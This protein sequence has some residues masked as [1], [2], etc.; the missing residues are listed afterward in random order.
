MGTL[1]GIA[2]SARRSDVKTTML[3][4]WAARKTAPEDATFYVA[5]GPSKARGRSAAARQQVMGCI[6]TLAA[7]SRQ[8]ALVGGE[9]RRGGER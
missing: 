3:A 9:A 6:S 4:E 8:R 5:R 1:E 7:N 2:P